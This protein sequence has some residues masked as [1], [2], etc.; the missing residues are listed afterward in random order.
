[1]YVWWYAKYT[2]RIEDRRKMWCLVILLCHF[3]GEREE[4]EKVKVKIELSLTLPYTQNSKG[5]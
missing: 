1:M 4:K 5:N 3:W 2:G